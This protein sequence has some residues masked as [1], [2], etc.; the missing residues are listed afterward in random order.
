MNSP[1][2]E[3][4]AKAVSP[5]RVQIVALEWANAVVPRQLVRGM[6]VEDD[7]MIEPLRGICHPKSVTSYDL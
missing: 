4:D 6:R 7:L 5:L 1:T 3:Y 2:A